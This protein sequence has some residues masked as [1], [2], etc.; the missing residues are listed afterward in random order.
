[1]ISAKH[2]GK[3]HFL[4]AVIGLLISTNDAGMRLCQHQP[5]FSVAGKTFLALCW[6]FYKMPQPKQETIS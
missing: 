4:A 1:L 2:S 3:K 6:L 5:E